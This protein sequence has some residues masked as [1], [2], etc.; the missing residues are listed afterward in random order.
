MEDAIRFRCHCPMASS[1]SITVGC[2]HRTP[3]R[4]TAQKAT[5]DLAQHLLNEHHKAVVHMGKPQ[6]VEA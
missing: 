4:E 2:D 5:M 3:W 1:T 6:V